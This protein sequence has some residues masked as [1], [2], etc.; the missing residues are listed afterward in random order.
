MIQTTIRIDDELHE[1][2]RSA[3]Y[4]KKISINKE[5]ILRLAGYVVM[6][7]RVSELES[8]KSKLFSDTL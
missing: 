6:K 8:S 7:E 2:L 5:I 1:D 4:K 3:A